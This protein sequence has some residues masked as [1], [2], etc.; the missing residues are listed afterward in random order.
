MFESKP[1]IVSSINFLFV[2]SLEIV[3]W[4]VVHFIFKQRVPSFVGWR[5]N[6][7]G[8]IW[9]SLSQVVCSFSALALLLDLTVARIG[10]FCA[11]T[12]MISWVERGVL[13]DTMSSMLGICISN[14]RSRPFSG[15]TLSVIFLF[16]CCLR[17]RRCCSAIFKTASRWR[18][19][20]P[21][22]LLIV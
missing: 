7:G 3:S 1:G 2:S 10:Q 20:N 9:V 5:G 16:Y 13:I 15:K 4:S 17:Y 6:N 12:M 11:L 19:R 22:T 18:H 8:R 14:R 21:F